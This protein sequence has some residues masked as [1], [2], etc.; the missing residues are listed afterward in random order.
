MDKE[1]L[2]KILEKTIIEGNAVGGGQIVGSQNP[3][4][5]KTNPNHKL[6]WKGQDPNK[7]LKTDS[8]INEEHKD[9]KNIKHDASGGFGAME[10]VD[11]EIP[12][13]IRLLWTPEERQKDL[14]TSSHINE[15]VSIEDL[16]IATELSK[17]NGAENLRSWA[18]QVGLKKIGFGATRTV[19]DFGND[20]V[21]KIA[22]NSDKFYANKF[23]A[24]TYPC[25]GYDYAAEVKFADE[26]GR[27]LIMEKVKKINNVIFEEKVAKLLNLSKDTFESLNGELGIIF[28]N[29]FINNEYTEQFY[30]QS[31]WYKGLFNRIKQCRIWPVDLAS[32]NFGIRQKTNQ[33]VLLDFGFENF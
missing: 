28:E 6:M 3:I 9:L 4:G 30:K 25:L 27:W 32:K 18:K 15:S 31:E 12:R 21:L 26:D 19:Y 22:N 13:M 2:R 14:K 5:M 7:D 16:K 8:E 23:E 1:S 20:L 17:E 10:P 24:Q 33:L 11:V 29:S